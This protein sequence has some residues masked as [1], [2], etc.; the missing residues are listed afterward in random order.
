MDNNITFEEALAQLEKIVKQLESGDTT[1][2]E[3]V[4]LFEKGIKLSELCSN[5]LKQAQ[6]KVEILINNDT[7]EPEFKDFNADE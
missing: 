4:K 7:E 5:Y 6:Q 3:S 2:D 1:L